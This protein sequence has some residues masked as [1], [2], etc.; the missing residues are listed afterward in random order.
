MAQ[1]VPVAPLAGAEAGS[2]GLLQ[3][4]QF[5]FGGRRYCWYFDGWHGPGWY[6]CGYAFRTG[7][8]WGGPRG[9]HSWRVPVR[10]IGP[11]RVG[12]PGLRAGRPGGAGA[13]MR[14]GG[15]PGGGMMRGRAGG[16]RPGGGR[17]GGRR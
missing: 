17:G 6:W 14:G 3:N 10:G 5:F 13:M 7:L 15:R 12:R 8:G 16:G 11:G 4:V 9:F 2:A 1:A